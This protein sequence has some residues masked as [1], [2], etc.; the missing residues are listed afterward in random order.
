MMESEKRTGQGMI[1]VYTGDGKGKTTAAL[2]LALR[3]VGRGLR[4]I[5][6]Q[7]LKGPEPTGEMLAAERCQPLLT[8]QPMG[9]SGFIGRRGPE[10]EDR[11]LAAE[12][13]KRVYAIFE[14]PS[15]DLLILDEVLV[16]VSFGLVSTDTVLDLMRKKPAPMELVLTGRSADPK[17]IEEA[18]LVTEM[19]KVKHYF[20]Q[21]MGDRLGI[22]R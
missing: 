4:V 6:I 17:I 10:P 13:V 5:V 7:F 21:G 9:R 16:A 14:N 2:G 20:D 19:K 11:R 12:A 18:D 15:C 1:H 8:I 3:A 22:E